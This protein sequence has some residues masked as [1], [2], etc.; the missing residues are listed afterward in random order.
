MSLSVCA[1]QFV[2]VNRLCIGQL[3]DDGNDYKQTNDGG[4]LQNLTRNI[5]YLVRKALACTLCI[6]KQ[7]IVC[8]VICHGLTVVLS[9]T[10]F[11]WKSQTTAVFAARVECGSYLSFST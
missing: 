9:K 2:T 4:N 3:T 1:S 6:W 10:Q 5:R 8:Q 11:S 7:G